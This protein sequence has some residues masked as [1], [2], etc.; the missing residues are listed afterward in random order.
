MDKKKINESV[1]LKIKAY[2]RYYWKE[3]L[4]QNDQ[5]EREVIDK[6]TKSL[7]AERSIRRSIP[8]LKEMR[9]SPGDVIFEV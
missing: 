5:R 7:R 9:Y 1:Q 4:L 3:A 8:L 2:L 6:L